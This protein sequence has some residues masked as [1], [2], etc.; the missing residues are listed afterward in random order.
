MVGIL[1]ITHGEIGLNLLDT[2]KNILGTVKTPV[3]CL[4]VSTKN[5]CAEVAERAKAIIERLSSADGLLILTDLYGATPYNI[6]N[7][8]AV[9][10]SNLI[11]GLNLSM[12]LRTLNYACLPLAELTDKAQQ[13][14]INGIQCNQ[15]AAH[16]E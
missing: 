7:N 9:E 13:G 12:L 14:G 10:N 1:L 8:L 2:A 4:S 16:V 6:A 3:A 15:Q 11:S 5:S